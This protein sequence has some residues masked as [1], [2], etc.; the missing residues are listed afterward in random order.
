MYFSMIRRKPTTRKL[1]DKTTDRWEHDMYREEE[2]GPK[3]K[4]ELEVRSEIVCILN[5]LNS[6]RSLKSLLAETKCRV[7]LATNYFSQEFVT[8]CL[9]LQNTVKPH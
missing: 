6:E 9:V 3:T 8:K 2:Q 7:R 4:E 5:V 1:W